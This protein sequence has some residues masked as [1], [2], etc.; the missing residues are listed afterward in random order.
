MSNQNNSQFIPENY[1]FEPGEH[2]GR[3]V[4][5]V[6]FPYDA[7][8]LS[9]L[10]TCAKAYWSQSHK[11][12]Y[13]Q[14]FAHYRD[15]F[16]MEKTYYGKA[17]LLN[18]SPINRPALTRFIEQLK[19]KAYS[20][21]TIKT[22]TTE[23]AQLLKT[24]KN[25]PVEE[26]S[27]EQLRSYLLYCI[28]KLKLSENLIH[29]RMNAVKFYFEQVLHREKI[30][31]DIPR[32]QKPSLL[33]K[34]ISTQDIKKMLD[35]LENHKHQLLLKMCY[36]MGLRVSEIVNLKI[37][38]IDSKRMQVL[39]HCSKGKK[40]RY[41]VLPES[42]LELLRTYY[43]E[44]KPKVFLFEGQGGGQYSI[45]SVQQVFKNAMK[46]ARINKKVGVHSLRHSYATHLIEQGTDIRFV[47]EL[48]GHNNIKTTMIYTALTDLSK[49]KIKSPLDNL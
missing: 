36:G 13:V 24:L 21:N 1:S 25:H 37:T 26:L 48:L 22:Y 45:R 47:Q 23:F 5:W 2:N 11:K 6:V 33:P 18:I 46:K 8:L 34:A 43:L 40:D 42:V 31:M 10:K 27:S 19:L 44:Y 35:V 3:K 41:V 16:G 29:S 32:P 15:L 30:F 12:W 39:V 9:E 38:D 4:I 7:Q 28:D 20:P 17:A 14:D 49:R